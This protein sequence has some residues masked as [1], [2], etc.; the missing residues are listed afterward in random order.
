MATKNNLATTIANASLS[1][2]IFAFVCIGIVT[3]THTQTQEKIAHQAHQAKLNLLQEVVKGITYDNDLLADTL[4]ISN[5][6]LL[7]IQDTQ[8]IYQAKQGSKVQAVILPV[9][10]FE[11]YSGQIKLLIAIDHNHTIINVRTLEHKETPGLGDKIEVKKS[12]WI[13]QFVGKNLTNTTDN[14]WKVKKHSGEFDQLSGAT[15]TS[16]ALIN[17]AYNALSYVRDNPELFN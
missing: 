9:N 16:K 17:A 14:Q 15:I 1:I 2:G 7:G 13:N 12:D 4:K 6:R 5:N 3:F 10:S 8:D 11:G